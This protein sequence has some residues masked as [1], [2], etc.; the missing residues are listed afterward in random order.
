MWNT[1]VGISR[2][3]LDVC[4]AFAKPRYPYFLDDLVNG[5]RALGCFA[6]LCG[7]RPPSVSGITWLHPAG[8]SRQAEMQLTCLPLTLVSVEIAQWRF[9]KIGGR[10]EADVSVCS[11]FIFAISLVSKRPTSLTSIERD[12]TMWHSV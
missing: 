12:M 9:D 4:D 11:A 1:S 5:A 2:H 3:S 6:V 7:A 8:P 10:V